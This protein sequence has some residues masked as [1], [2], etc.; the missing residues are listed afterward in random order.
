VRAALASVETVR[1]GGIKL[2]LW[3]KNS[4]L[5]ALGPPASHIRGAARA[6]QA[7]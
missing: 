1:G 5:D 6:W 7:G 3:N 2:K 4:A